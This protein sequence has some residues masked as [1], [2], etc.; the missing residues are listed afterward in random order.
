MQFN[1]KWFALFFRLKRLD[2]VTT[3]KMISLLGETIIVHDERLFPSQ[4]LIRLNK[5]NR[6][7]EVLG[8][9]KSHRICGVRM[10]SMRNVMNIFF[11]E[12]TFGIQFE[13]INENA[14]V[15]QPKVCARTH[16]PEQQIRKRTSSS[17]FN[18]KKKRTELGIIPQWHYIRRE[19]KKASRMNVHKLAEI[20][21]GVCDQTNNEA[22]NFNFCVWHIVKSKPLPFCRKLWFE[23]LLPLWFFAD[24]ESTIRAACEFCRFWL[25]YRR[26]PLCTRNKKNRTAPNWNGSKKTYM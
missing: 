14:S 15:W 19:R 24:D 13:T 1:K 6:N 11:Y 9:E 25:H 18:A 8:V 3:R 16:Q 26:V 2:S 21:V 20:S 10:N 5:S 17:K 4:I 23:L 7:I 22:N 12:K